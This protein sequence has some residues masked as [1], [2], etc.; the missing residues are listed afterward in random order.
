MGEYQEKKW[1]GTHKRSDGE[2]REEEEDGDG[3][4]TSTWEIID[5]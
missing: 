5:R 3:M 1:M 2:I 4:L